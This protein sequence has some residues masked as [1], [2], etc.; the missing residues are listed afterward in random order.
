MAETVLLVEDD[1]GLRRLAARLLTKLG[2]TVVAAAGADSAVARYRDNVDGID[3]LITDVFMPDV[4]GPELARRLLVIRPDLKVLYVSGSN[5]ALESGA[6]AAD[7]NFLLKPFTLD[8]FRKK[9]REV[10]DQ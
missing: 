8:A 1:P 9:I 10:L 7:A 5:E 6:L 2:Y 3:L 4:G